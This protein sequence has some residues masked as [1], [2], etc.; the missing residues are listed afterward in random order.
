[1][2]GESEQAED[3]IDETGTVDTTGLTLGEGGEDGV[4]RMSTGEVRQMEVLSALGVNEE[5]LSIHGTAPGVKGEGVTRLI[6][7]NM[8]GLLNKIGGNEKLEKAKAIIDD[9]EVDIACFNEHK[10]NL[11]HKDNVNGFSQLFQGGEAEVRSVAAHN[12]HEGRTV[13]HRQEGGTA[14]LVFRHLVEQYDFEA[15]GRDASGLGRWAVLVFRGSNDIVTRV[16]CGYCPC[17]SRKQATRSSYQQ[18]RR[19]Y[20]QKEQDLT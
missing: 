12:R 4:G 13:G 10:Q 6:Y 2:S 11:M 17:V 18:A 8:D 9:L 15:S 19:F 14:A 20:I 5:V 16:V 3:P 1:M 7:E